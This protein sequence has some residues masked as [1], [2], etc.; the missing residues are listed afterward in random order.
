M[1]NP[2]A[3]A[4]PFTLNPGDIL[5]VAA[6]SFAGTDANATTLYLSEEI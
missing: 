3:D 4:A 5:I 2:D 1:S 6:R